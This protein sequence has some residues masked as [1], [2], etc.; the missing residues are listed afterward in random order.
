MAMGI[1]FFYLFLRQERPWTVRR[2]SLI[3]GQW[4]ERQEGG[5]DASGPG[6]NAML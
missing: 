2:D 1:T 6:G 3:N 5:A 4:M